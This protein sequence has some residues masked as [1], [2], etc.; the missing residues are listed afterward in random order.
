MDIAGHVHGVRV[1]WSI[2]DATATGAAAAA[3]TPCTIFVLDAMRHDVLGLGEITQHSIGLDRQTKTVHRACRG[4]ASGG[5]SG[6]HPSINDQNN[7]ETKSCLVVFA[8]IKRPTATT[9]TPQFFPYPVLNLSP[10]NPTDC[11]SWC[12]PTRPAG[13][14]ARRS[15]AS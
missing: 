11:R 6:G 14:N 2:V 4:G 3:P 1:G 8:A 12:S 13:S 7:T 10:N 15:L 9:T 5:A